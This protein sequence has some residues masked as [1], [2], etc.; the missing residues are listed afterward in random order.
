MTCLNNE[1]IKELEKQG[2]SDEYRLFYHL[3]PPV[4]WLNDPNGLCQLNGR[5]HLYYQYAPRDCFGSGG[6]YWGHY[7]TSD[8]VTF[9]NEDVALFPDSPLDQDGVYSGAAIV[10]NEQMYVYYTGNV[11]QA[12]DHDYIHSGR[13]HNTIMVKSQDGNTFSK[14]VCLMKNNDYPSN[15]TCHVRDPQV[16]KNG[17]HYNMILG[18]RTSEDV[19]CCLIYRSDDLENWTYINQITS[20]EPFGYMW[21]CPNLVKFE[22]QMVLF[23][24][25]QGV[26]KQGYNYENLYQNGYY[27]VSGDLEDQYEL[28]DFIDFDHGF[29][30]YAPQLFKDE[31][32]RV[33][34]I[35]WMGLPDVPYQNATVAD[36]WQHALSLP[37]VLTFKNHKVY[38]YPLEE[39]KALRKSKELINLSNNTKITCKSNIYEL[40]LP[41]NNHEFSLQL[42]S[43]VTI[44]Y[45]DGLLTFAMKDSGCGRDQRHIVIDE[46]ENMTIFSDSS[47]LE[48]FFN[49]GQYALT[50]RIYDHSKDLKI[51]IDTNIQC[52]YYE[53]NKYQII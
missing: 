37:R 51:S 24:C 25:P 29:D 20:K 1:Q 16:I 3:M 11:K 8:F 38:Q 41:I 28:S 21:E 47:S 45:H 46:L 7:S 36:N 2:S 17:D 18:A 34:M 19:G 50:S 42:R 12:G 6:K 35:G 27:L 40:Y 4:G 5:Y 43:D 49:D 39:T 9:K 32:G 23:C 15:L 10:E 30:Y 44:D 53:L 13:Q 52:T 14:K 26:E 22:E 31:K 33:I 48:I